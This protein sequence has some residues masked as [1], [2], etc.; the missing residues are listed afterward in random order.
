MSEDRPALSV[1][2]KDT[3]SKY[4]TPH[5][6][7]TSPS[8]VRRAQTAERDRQTVQLRFHGHTFEAIAQQLGHTNRSAA[9]KSFIR[10]LE[11]WGTN[12]VAEGRAAEAARLDYYLT[13]IAPQV[14]KGSLLAIDRAVKIS[15]RRSKLLGLDAPTRLTI[16]DEALEAERE[17]LKGE[18]GHLR[19][20]AGGKA[21]P[22]P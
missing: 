15:E 17:R 3:R 12:D 8:S 13:T 9:R 22:A 21:A 5:G 14:A 10:G 6:G 18:V 19:S 1:V 2:N 4:T 11:H 20:I 7:S 16:T